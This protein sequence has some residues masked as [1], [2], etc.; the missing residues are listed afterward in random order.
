MLENLNG[1][2]VEEFMTALE[3]L[4]KVTD[5]LRLK[6]EEHIAELQLELCRDDHVSSLRGVDK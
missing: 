5:W 2:E 3:A 1:A 6:R 4:Y